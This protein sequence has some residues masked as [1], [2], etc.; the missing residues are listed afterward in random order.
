MTQVVRHAP[1]FAC[2]DPLAQC[3]YYVEKLGFQVVGEP[4]PDYG[5]VAFEGHEVHFHGGVPAVE[6]RSDGTFA[7]RGGAYFLVD[8]PDALHATVKDLGARIVYAPQDRPYGLRDFSV[9]DPEGYSVCFG[10]PLA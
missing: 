6:P 10:R 2:A 3:R 4:C 9:V 7:Y 5:M 1:V 8:D